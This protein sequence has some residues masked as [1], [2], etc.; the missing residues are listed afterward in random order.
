MKRKT[1]ICP[2][3]KQSWRDKPGPD[4]QIIDLHAKGLSTGQIAEALQMNRIGIWRKIIALGLTPNPAPSRKGMKY[5]P[6]KLTDS[7]SSQGS[8]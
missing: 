6:R 7:K 4:Q 5:G 2:T 1:P 3:C 8:S